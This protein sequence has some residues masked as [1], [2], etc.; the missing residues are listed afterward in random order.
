MVIW[1]N[2]AFGS[3]K[4]TVAQILTEKIGKSYIYDPEEVGFFLWDVFPEEM[5]RKGNFQHI[6]LWRDFNFRILRYVSSQYDGTVI[7]PMTIYTPEYYGE[8]IEH[9]AA[10]GICLRHFILD[11]EKETLLK[12]LMQRGESED[13][14]AARHIDICLKAFAEDIKDEKIRTDDISAEEVADEI[15]RRLKQSAERLI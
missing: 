2:G 7:V 5:K 8:I 3:G 9:L 13:S 4:S 11:A 15:L 10:D 6:P 1:L 14:W 12:R